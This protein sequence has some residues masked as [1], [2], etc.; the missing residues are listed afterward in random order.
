MSELTPRQV[1]F[2]NEY[3]KTLN[4][5]QSAVKGIYKKELQNRLV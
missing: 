5:T 4:I 3:I 2:V 1:R